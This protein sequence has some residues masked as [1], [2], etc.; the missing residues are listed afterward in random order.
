MRTCEEYR[1]LFDAYIARELPR[2]ER[3]ELEVHIEQCPEC[4]KLLSEEEKLF[5]EDIYTMPASVSEAVME[6][7]NASA[8]GDLFTNEEER[9]S[10]EIAVRKQLRKRDAIKSWV[11]IAIVIG[12]AVG[13]YF[14]QDYML[15]KNPSLGGMDAAPK[16][17]AVMEESAVEDAVTEENKG[18]AAPVTDV[19]AKL[20][21]YLVNADNLTIKFGT[22]KAIIYEHFEIEYL[23]DYIVSCPYEKIEG[24]VNYKSIGSITPEPDYGINLQITDTHK[25]ILTAGSDIYEIQ[26]E[27]EDLLYALEG[28]G[29]LS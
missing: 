19:L 20:R 7:V 11:L 5:G 8:I 25:I 22:T 29:I 28:V 12:F 10:M 26:T 6:K 21:E 1:E 17:E 24:R 13:Y 15:A 16:E 4:S 18:S 27:R 3:M 9:E 23:A 2:T 14:L